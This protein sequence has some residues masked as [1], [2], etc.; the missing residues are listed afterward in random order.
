MTFFPLHWLLRIISSFTKSIRLGKP[1]TVDFTEAPPISGEILDLGG[2]GEGVVGRLFG[3][4]VT[5][6]DKRQEELDETREGPIKIV[7]DAKSL[8]LPDS[9][10]DSVTAFYFLMYVKPTE[11]SQIFREAFRTLK[12]GGVFYIWDTV[13]PAC[14]EPIRKTFVVPVIV[15]MNNKTIQT[16]YGVGWKDR[17]L[18]PELLTEIALNTGFV[19]KSEKRCEEAFFMELMKPDKKSETESAR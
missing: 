4:R 19:V 10:F 6:V 14:E 12:T 2:G 15:K 18:S 9:S 8:P 17:M 13:I 11:Y 3:Q 16:A 7:A 5:A 1:Q